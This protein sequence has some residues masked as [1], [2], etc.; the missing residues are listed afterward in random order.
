MLWIENL[1]RRKIK[2]KIFLEVVPFAYDICSWSMIAGEITF[3]WV[4]KSI[5]MTKDTRWA[6]TKN[7]HFINVL[8]FLITVCSYA[9]LFL[10]VFD[11]W[12]NFWNSTEENSK[13]ISML[14]SKDHF[15]NL[16]FQHISLW[17]IFCQRFKKKKK[18]EIL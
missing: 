12:R 9:I 13:W 17:G 1:F 8:F 16:V 11:K 14:T 2:F 7:N 18:M 10:K 5:C 15:S 4:H 6:T 3:I